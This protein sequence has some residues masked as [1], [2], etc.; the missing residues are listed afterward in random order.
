MI[1]VR[2]GNAIAGGRRCRRK[3]H[4]IMLGGMNQRNALIALTALIAVIS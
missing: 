4:M 3:V 1:N 2:P